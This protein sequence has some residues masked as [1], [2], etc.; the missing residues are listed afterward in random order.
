MDLSK[1]YQIL[2]SALQLTD[3]EVAKM[4]GYN[5]RVSFANSTR[6]DKVIAGMVSLA[7]S[8]GFNFETGQTADRSVLS[9]IVGMHGKCLLGNSKVDGM[10]PVES[11]RL[12]SAEGMASVA[13]VAAD[14]LG[15]NLLSDEEG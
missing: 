1:K 5:G 10:T 6:R 8:F 2:K 4:F 14:H 12:G 11:F 9:E 15:I 3:D 7:E 13:G